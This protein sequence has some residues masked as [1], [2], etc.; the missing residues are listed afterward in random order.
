M[1]ATIGVVA[2]RGTERAFRERAEELE[3]SSLSTWATLAAETKGRDRFEEPDP[4][5][6]AFADDLDRL[7]AT[8]A[9]GAL[10]GKSARMP[11]RL[12]RTRLLET[13]DVVR[14][15]RTLG[16]AL[17]LNPDL[18]EAVASG[19]ALGSPPFGDAGG[20][21]LSTF[22]VTPFHPGEQALRVVESPVVGGRA[23]NLTWEVR[24]GLL[25]HDPGGPPGATTEAQTVRL[26]VGIVRAV[27]PV[28]DLIVGGLL[29]AAD[30]PISVRGALGTD[31]QRWTSAL[32]HQAAEISI[33]GPEVRLDVDATA[34]V[35]ALRAF[36]AERA[37]RDEVRADHDRAV[38]VLRSILVFALEADGDAAGAVDTVVAATD[39]EALARYRRLFEPGA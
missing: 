19:H 6:T 25:H 5:R 13:L 37:A 27:A 16:R 35:A 24:D 2:K 30:V 20:E 36:T 26:A 11:A 15:A 38:H 31:P 32:I 17:Q 7:Q 10:A 29:A 23:L 39:A 22:T 1:V 21:A 12:G 8:A 34:A 4:L 9:F 14:V 33:E 18:V 28:R 3:R